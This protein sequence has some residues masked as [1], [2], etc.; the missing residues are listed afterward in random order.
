MRSTGGFTLAEVL[1]AVLI[2]SVGLLAIAA[3]SGS[4][5]RMLGYGKTSTQV[6]HIVSSRLEVL[7][8]EANRTTPRCLSAGL[9]G[10]SDT[11]SNNVVETWSVSGTGPSRSIMV[12]VTTPSG[13]GPT[14]D[15][16]TS[17][18]DCR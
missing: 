16:I 11:A 9:V 7:R 10:G 18:L 5:Y 17:L 3:S 1:V 8:R 4:V 13:H 6:A 2:L 12:V 15:T 14:S